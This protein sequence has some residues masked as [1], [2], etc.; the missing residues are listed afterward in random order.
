[1]ITC[2]ICKDKIEVKFIVYD[3]IMEMNLCEWCYNKL[4]PNVFSQEAT[5]EE[6]VET[7]KIITEENIDNNFVSL[8]TNPTQY[9]KALALKAGKVKSPPFHT[10]FSHQVWI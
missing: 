7:L 1:M 2:E 8:I 3:E 5:S 9:N 4:R 10:R 6:I